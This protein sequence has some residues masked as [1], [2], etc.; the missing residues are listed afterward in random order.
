MNQRCK[1]APFYGF[2]RKAVVVTTEEEEFKV[3]YLCLFSSSLL[4][5]CCF[6]ACDS[7]ET[8]TVTSSNLKLLVSVLSLFLSVC[9]TRF[10]SMLSHSLFK[11]I[12]SSPI[13]QTRLTE[14]EKVGSNVPKGIMNEIKLNFTIPKVEENKEVS[15]FDDV[16]FV[17]VED[18]EKVDE[19]VNK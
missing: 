19:I 10:F 18:K 17:G 8:L 11:F 1:M 16:T 7:I 2:H 14:L 3:G 5:I 4:V 9:P 13:A 12:S 15:A 6:L